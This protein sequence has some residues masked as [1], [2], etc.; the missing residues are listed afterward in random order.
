M[1]CGEYF[2]TLAGTVQCEWFRRLSF[3]SNRI[4]FSILFYVHVNMC[5]L[6]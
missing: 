3:F 6:N 5:W 1:I 4:L 2:Q